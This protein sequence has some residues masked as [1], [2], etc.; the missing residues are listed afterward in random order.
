LPI[1]HYF[2]PKKFKTY[3]QKLSWQ[4][5]LVSRS[6]LESATVADTPKFAEANPDEVAMLVLVLCEVAYPDLSPSIH[7]FAEERQEQLEALA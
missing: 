3:K 4:E 6:N 5:D 2:P 1:Q 7:S